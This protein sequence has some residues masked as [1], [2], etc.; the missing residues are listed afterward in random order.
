VA[1]DVNKKNK[2]PKNKGIL[3]LFFFLNCAIK[4]CQLP[5]IHNYVW[6]SF[7]TRIT[8]RVNS[9]GVLVETTSSENQI[10]ESLFGKGVVVCKDQQAMGGDLLILLKEGGSK[11]QKCGY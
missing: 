6:R 8:R 3:S 1:A 5:Q 9:C 4:S 2:T 10:G 11:M 7:D